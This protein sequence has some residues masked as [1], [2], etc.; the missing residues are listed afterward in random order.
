MLQQGY[1]ADQHQAGGMSNG[2]EQKGVGRFG[3]VA[4]EEIGAAPGKHGGQTKSGR[5]EILGIQKGSPAAWQR[6]RYVN[7][8]GKHWSMKRQT[9]KLG[10]RCAGRMRQERR[11]ITLVIWPL[12]KHPYRF[13]IG[14]EWFGC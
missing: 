9:T 2:G 12:P 7:G 8:R 11:P 14:D 10:G 5:D 3:G 4:A 13:E 6:R 1:G